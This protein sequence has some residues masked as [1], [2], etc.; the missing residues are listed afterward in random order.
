[1]GWIHTRFMR[2]G[3]SLNPNPSNQRKGPL[4]KIVG[5]VNPEGASVGLFCRPVVE[6]ECGHTCMSDGQ[7]KARCRQCAK[8]SE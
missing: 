4:R 3:R 5:I 8:V 2:T 1:M 6:L 7:F